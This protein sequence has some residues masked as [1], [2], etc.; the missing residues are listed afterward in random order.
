MHYGVAQMSTA[1]WVVGAAVLAGGFGRRF[2]GLA[3]AVAGAAAGALAL[4][5]LGAFGVGLDAAPYFLGGMMLAGGFP[6]FS[7]TERAAKTKK[8]TKPE[9]VELTAEQ[10]EH[11][12]LLTA[13]IDSVSAPAKPLEVAWLVT[14]VGPENDDVHDLQGVCASVQEALGVYGTEHQRLVWQRE[15]PRSALIGGDFP[16]S[17]D[18]VLSSD[19]AGEL[20]RVPDDSFRTRGV[21]VTRLFHLPLAPDHIIAVPDPKRPPHMV[22]PIG[23]VGAGTLKQFIGLDGETTDKHFVAFGGTG[24]GKSTIAEHLAFATA[25]DGLPLA[26]LDPHGVNTDNVLDYIV[27]FAPHRLDDVVMLDPGDAEGKWS[28]AYNPMAVCSRADVE[29]AHHVVMDLLESQAGLDSSATRARPWLL[30]R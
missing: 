25:Y 18:F 1:P 29:P 13:K 10:L 3:G 7:V 30:R 23:S 6:H 11:V 19:E 16:R 27:K 5:V 8:P 12:A 15:D 20:A 9:R 22:L 21:K 2:S 14:V 28:L 24:S 17:N 26:W 4:K